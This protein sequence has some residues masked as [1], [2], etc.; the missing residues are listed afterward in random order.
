MKYLI[1]VTI[2]FGVV[3]FISRVADVEFY[4]AMTVINLC[5]LVDMMVRD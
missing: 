3:Y 5:M 2:T 4:K 1:A